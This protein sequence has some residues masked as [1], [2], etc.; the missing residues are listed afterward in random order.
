MPP[1]KFTPPISTLVAPAIAS[2]RRSSNRNGA[3]FTY[4]T[5]SGGRGS[6]GN[7]DSDRHIPESIICSKCNQE[8]RHGTSGYCKSCYNEYVRERYKK[9]IQSNIS[10][11]AMLFD[12]HAPEHDSSAWSATLAWLRKNKPDEIVLGG[13]VLELGS[14]SAHG[15]ANMR[16][17]VEDFEHGKKLIAEI[18]AT[19]GA[20]ITYL[21]GNHETRLSRFLTSQAPALR[22][23]L[24]LPIGLDLDARNISY[25]PED[26]QPIAR[27]N[28]LILHGHQPFPKMIPKIYAPKI[29]DLYGDGD[30]TI[31]VGHAHRAQMYSRPGKKLARVFGSGCLRTL[32]P[33]WLRGQPVG[34]EH[35]FLVAEI[36]KGI[37]RVRAIPLY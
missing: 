2:K 12:I 36:K 27:G 8:P 22:A 18:R 11:I 21:E 30:C 31:C 17:L 14:V 4:K 25:I 7:I 23:S 28:L 6:R 9:I 5:G 24:S 10:T 32:S 16:L 15:D 33:G 1:G 26:R 29:A 35:G 37:A 3:V 13:D 19:C 34:W 20:K